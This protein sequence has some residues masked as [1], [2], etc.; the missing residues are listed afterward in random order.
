MT[1]NKE[2]PNGLCSHWRS[3]RL[4][5]NSCCVNVHRSKRTRNGTLLYKRENALS[6]RVIKLQCGAAVEQ[7]IL[8]CFFLFSCFNVLPLLVSVFYLKILKKTPSAGFFGVTKSN[9]IKTLNFHRY[10]SYESLCKVGRSSL[11]IYSF[12]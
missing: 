9:V 11:I 12:W 3:F 10:P 2:I 4:K 1:E 6:S 8:C 5:D 7:Q